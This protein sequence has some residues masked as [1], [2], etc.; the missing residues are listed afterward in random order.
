MVVFSVWVFGTFCSPVTFDQGSW[1]VFVRNNLNRSNTLAKLYSEL[2]LL[3]WHVCRANFGTK[4]FFVEA[5]IFLQKMLWKFPQNLWASIF[6]FR[7]NPAKFP[8]NFLQYFPPKNQKNHLR[9]SAGVQGECLKGA[10]EDFQRDH[11]CQTSTCMKIDFMSC[12]CNW[13]ETGKFIECFRGRHRGGAILL[14][15]CGSPD[16]FFMQQSEP[17][18]A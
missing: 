5:R 2:V 9:A 7:K 10:F 1:S 8:P 4:C 15:F 13:P 6:C 18:L 17:F 3:G 11:S 16:P 12:K 14:H